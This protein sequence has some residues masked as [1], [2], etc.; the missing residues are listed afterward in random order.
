MV[1]GLDGSAG[2]AIGIELGR[3]RV[4]VTALGFDG[5]V[6]ATRTA[7][8]S[9]PFDPT[10][11]LQTA[12]VLLQDLLRRKAI[13]SS[14]LVGI[15]VAVA[16]RHAPHEHPLGRAEVQ[17]DPQDLDL[18][19]LRARFAV[20]VSWDNNVRLAAVAE[21]QRDNRTPDLIYVAL[22]AGVSCGVVVNGTVLR[23]GGAAGE[24]GHTSI[25]PRGPRCW[26]GGRGCLETYLGTEELLRQAARAGMGEITL[27]DLL[28]ACH[29]G[30]RRAQK[31]IGKAGMRL[32]AALANLLV[33]LDTPVVVLGG[34]LAELDDLL[35][36]PVQRAAQ[37]RNLGIAH[38]ERTFR[39]SRTGTM[40]PSIGAGT[41]A[42]T[43]PAVWD[44]RIDEQ[45]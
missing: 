30:E 9:A 5:S 21:A 35:L 26:C 32:G 33:V 39:I 25:D 28:R 27:H 38:R 16:G 23:G 7:E 14:L 2:A 24:F 6:I 37:T 31:I 41:L 8:D 15:G 18:S 44:G 34:E 17:P 19:W 42:L 40:A 13:N 29:Q 20:P 3:S 22:S 10:A 1:L 4:T 12:R 11:R 43:G 36:E 45:T